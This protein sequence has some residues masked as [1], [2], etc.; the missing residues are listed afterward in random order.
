[1]LRAVAIY[2]CRSEAKL[3]ARQVSWRALP[4]SVKPGRSHHSS[5]LPVG[6]SPVS[7]SIRVHM[8]P[9]RLPCLR[10]RN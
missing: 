6:N 9:N 7:A 1:M 2:T 5:I 10:L 4:S 8:R 3:S